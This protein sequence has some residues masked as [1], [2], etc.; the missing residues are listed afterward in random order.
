MIPE[1]KDFIVERAASISCWS[2]SAARSATSRACHSSRRSASSATICGHVVFIHLTLFVHSDRR[3]DQPNSTARNCAESAIQPHILLSMRSEIATRE[4][5]RKLGLFC[6]VRESAVVE[7][8]DAPSIYGYLRRSIMPPASTGRCS[9]PL[10]LSLRQ[11]TTQWDSVSN[12]GPGRGVDR[13]GRQVHRPEGRLQIADRGADPQRHGQSRT[14]QARLE[15]E[16]FES[17]DPAPRAWG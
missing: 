17:A 3:R 11:S 16:I 9:P 7:A 10:A 6:N 5:R 2:R 12:H 8:R 13:R 14:G 15:S 4:E 1:F